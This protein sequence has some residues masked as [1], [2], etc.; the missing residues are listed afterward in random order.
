[1][2]KR[3]ILRGLLAGAVGG[4]LAFLFARIFAEP[5]IR[6]AVD[7]EDGRERAQAALDRAAGIAA[8]Q[9]HADP[10]S[11]TVQGNAGIGV[12]MIF[13]GVAM[14]ALFAVAYAICL[15]R[16][17]RV[18]P[19]SLAVLVAGGGFLSLCLVP[20]LKYPANPPAIGHDDTIRLRSSFYLLMVAC[21]V[22]FLI[23]TVW[24]GRRLQPRYGTWNAALI[25]GGVFIVAV[26]V[27]MLVLP[28]FGELAANREYHQATETPA[29]L[30]DP[31]GTVVFPGFPADLLYNFRLYSIGAQLVLWTAIGLV[32]APLAERLLE[33]GRART[34]KDRAA[35]P[36]G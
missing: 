27:V 9:A 22:L 2:E 13:F 34:G 15:G 8:E 29:P 31:N 10:F 3:L 24:L 21:S 28:S 26:G 7:Y 11:R 12:A 23:L 20:F 25:A 5:Q 14:G 18:R 16:T 30:T 19:R 1:M 35:A 6:Q 33:P 4:V 32:F 36:I 17:G